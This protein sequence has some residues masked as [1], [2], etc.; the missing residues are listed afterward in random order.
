MKTLLRWLILPALVVGFGFLL[1]AQ[2]PGEVRKSGKILLLKTGLAMEGDKIEHIGSQMCIRRG[3]SEVW[4]A[5]DKA[6]RLCPD[7]TDAYV[8]MQ[9]HIKVDNAND[10]V[11]LA[12]WCHVH[13]LNTEALAE[14]KLA[15]ELEPGHA[16]AKQIVSMLER[17]MKDPPAKPITPKPTPVRVDGPTPTVDV[18]AD[19]LIAFMSKVQPILMNTCA[20]CHTGDTAGKFRLERVSETGHKVSSQ[21]NLAA[22]LGQVDL[23]RPA[24]SPLLVKA[25]TPHGRDQTPPIKDRSAKP[26]QFVQQWIVETVR[27]NPQLKLYQEVKKPAA[28]QRP[29]EEKPTT[30]S[31]QGS[32]IPAGN[33]DVISRPVP[34]LDPNLVK[35]API[36]ETRTP[37]AARERDW[38]DPDWYNEWAHPR[39]TTP[40][41]AQNGR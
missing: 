29:P 32:A 26:F 36:Q 8:F 20:S 25:I 33:D 21:R 19:T 1:R 3:V 16:D 41:V 24:I 5:D 10:R 15:L 12:R 17:A 6:V 11:K 9:S 39:G 27:K 13:R 38:C 37:V 31:S 4:I 35:P 22:V 28:F 34:R 7:W 18:T 14:A 30:F 40:Q 2:E 23:D